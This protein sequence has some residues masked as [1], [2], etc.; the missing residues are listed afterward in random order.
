M[1]QAPLLPQLMVLVIH[2]TAAP[3]PLS[4]GQ[5]G[6]YGITVYGHCVAVGFTYQPRVR[7]RAHWWGFTDRQRACPLSGLAL[8]YG[9][10]GVGGVPFEKCRRPGVLMAFTLLHQPG[11]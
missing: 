11:L 4:L 2:S 7:S 8:G 6:A 5:L 3:M 10:H 9:A 1:E